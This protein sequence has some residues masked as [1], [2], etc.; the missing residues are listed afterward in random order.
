MEQHDKA[1]RRMGLG[2]DQRVSPLIGGL[3]DKAYTKGSTQDAKRT[4][5]FKRR[6]K[7]SR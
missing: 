6:T 1:L 2:G 5:R 4:K 7:K 3:G